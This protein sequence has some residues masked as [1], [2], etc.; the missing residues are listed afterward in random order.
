MKRSILP[1]GAIVS[2]A[3]LSGCGDKPAES[4][5]PPAASPQPSDA[6]E[7]TQA[8][9]KAVNEA[10][11]E[12]KKEAQAAYAQLSQQ[13]L[14]SSKGATD[15][16]L[17][18]VSTDLQG[19][20]QKLGEALKGNEALTQQLGS[21]VNALLGNKDS[22]AVTSLGGLTAAKL[23]P[24]QTTLAKDVY[25][26][27]AAL[28]TQRN[29]SSLEGLNSDVSQLANA[30]WKGNYTQALPPLQKIYNQA[31]LTPAQKDLLGKMY[32]SYMPA[33]WKDSATKLQQGLDSLKKIGQ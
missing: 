11:A 25:N 33:G 4:S 1:F 6:S 10:V 29:F 18:N 26:A 24:E 5:A 16:L 17:K 3:L 13:L 14:A 27:T 15:E 22:E 21:A 19:R 28:V 30:V 31:T 23:T 12:V 32:D 20:V 8:A 7:A 9:S 2:L